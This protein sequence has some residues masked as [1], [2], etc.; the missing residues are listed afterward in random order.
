[1]PHPSVPHPSVAGSGETTLE[2]TSEGFNAL[3]QRVAA[4]I[5]ARTARGPSVTRREPA[6]PSAGCTFA[7][8]E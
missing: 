5:V 1:V 3:P 8:S 6:S 7:G 4:D 2:D